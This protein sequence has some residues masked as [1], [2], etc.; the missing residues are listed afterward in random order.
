MP[1]LNNGQ[2]LGN[3]DRMSIS[4]VVLCHLALKWLIIHDNRKY[5]ERV[6][7]CMMNTGIGAGIMIPAFNI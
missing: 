7:Y 1:S 6:F 3:A 4:G 5:V 2:N